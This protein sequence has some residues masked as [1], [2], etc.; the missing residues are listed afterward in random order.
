[1]GG[2]NMNSLQPQLQVSNIDTHMQNSVIHM[3]VYMHI[4]ACRT[5]CCS[6]NLSTA[7]RIYPDS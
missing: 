5:R 6:L 4:H 3:L 1:M 2:Y 7:D